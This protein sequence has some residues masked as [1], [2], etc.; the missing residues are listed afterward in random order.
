M[1][2]EY[3]ALYSQAFKLGNYKL[4]EIILLMHHIVNAFKSANV[5][6]KLNYCLALN[7]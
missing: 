2:L 7:V 3:F 6:L 1:C 4:D 5:K